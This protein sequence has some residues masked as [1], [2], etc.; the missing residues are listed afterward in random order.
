MPDET[1]ARL[2]SLAGEPLQK[3]QPL[4]P[5]TLWLAG[6]SGEGCFGLVGCAVYEFHFLFG[7]QFA[8]WGKSVVDSFLKGVFDGPLPPRLPFPH[9]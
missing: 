7:K 1:G 3:R 6:A 8:F 2:D 5:T 9:S 4:Q